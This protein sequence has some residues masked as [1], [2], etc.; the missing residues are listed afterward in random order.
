MVKLIRALTLIIVVSGCSHTYQPKPDT[1]K[2]DSFS[3]FTA[4]VDIS[5]LNTQTDNTDRVHFRNMGHT[6]SGNMKSWTDTAVIIVKREL[7]KR[8]ATI[9]DGSQRRLELSIIFIEGEAGFSVIH[10][11]TK[12][13]V[14]TGS[15]YEGIYTGDNRSP[16]SVWRAADGAVMRAVT[17]MFRDPMIVEYITSSN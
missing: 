8:Q 6:L 3:E 5:I 7:T 9:F 2:M 4:P 13:K 12:L 10:Y 16:A 15:G 14:K 17:E 1:F 11:I